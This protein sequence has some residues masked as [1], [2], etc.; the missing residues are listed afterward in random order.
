MEILEK[1]DSDT[2][3]TLDMNNDLYSLG[4]HLHHDHGC[5][6]PRD[7]DRH[8]QFAILE[9]VSPTNIEV[10]E[11]KWMHRLNCFQPVGINVE[12]PFG[13]PYLEQN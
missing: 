10:K 4:L 2:L 8:F 1:I 3:D 7:F 13:L 6:D 5:V 12:Y 11:F 9:V